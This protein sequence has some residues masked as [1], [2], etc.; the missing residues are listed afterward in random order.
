[1]LVW[2]PID[3]RVCACRLQ[4]ELSGSQLAS[5]ELLC[6]EVVLQLAG[7]WVAK[8]R[9]AAPEISPADRLAGGRPACERRSLCLEFKRGF[10]RHLALPAGKRS[11][12]RSACR[13]R[14]RSGALCR[15]LT[16]PAEQQWTLPL[17]TPP[18]SSGSVQATRGGS[19]RA[20]WTSRVGR[21]RER[22]RQRGAVCLPCAER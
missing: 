21:K 8:S 10:G 6:S 3:R 19:L 17:A 20:A 2:A 9:Q 16:V 7:K 1:M 18:A 13:R 4:G 12:H 22:E 15:P 14:P 5:S 11:R